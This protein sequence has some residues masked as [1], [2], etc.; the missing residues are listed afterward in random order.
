MAQ[1]ISQS[2]GMESQAVLR[3]AMAAPMLGKEDELELARRWREERDVESLT[4]LT[5]SYL[6]LVISMASRFRSYGLPVADL[7]QEGTV[8]LMEA[9][10]RFEPEREIRFSTYASWWIRSSMQDYIL[11]N[12]SIV[13]TG[14]T[15]AHKSLF[16]NLRR[17][18]A[19]IVGDYDGPMT[20][21]SR[22]LLADKLGVRLKDVE[23]MEARL[24]GYD[25]SLNAMVGEDGESEWM[26]FLASDAP[27]PDEEL[28]E[29]N[30]SRVKTALLRDAMKILT[31]REMTIIRERRL[32][33]DSVT[34]AAL[35]ERLGISKERV[36]QIETQ[37]LNKLRSALIDRVG[38][39][40]S[41][42]LVSSYG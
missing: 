30:D 7:I 31:E 39:P 4:A 35:G 10:G 5:R 24:T 3:A 36:R 22:Q 37:A 13:R 9:A 33:D 12:W 25:R 6:R 1:K 26:D 20:Y 40:V 28:E 18:R 8:G 32:G 16:F 14:T 34:L 15:A 42:G 29:I 38:D 11:R 21:A 27:Q 23:V 19:Q 2:S 41:A 17:L